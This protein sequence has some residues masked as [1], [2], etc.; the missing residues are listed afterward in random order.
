[1]Q[2]AAPQHEVERLANI[3]WQSIQEEPQEDPQSTGLRG[4][5]R[6]KVYYQLVRASRSRIREHK[7]P[8]PFLSARVALQTLSGTRISRAQARYEGVTGGNLTVREYEELL[9]GRFSLPIILVGGFPRSGTTSLQ[10][11]IRAGFPNHVCEVGDGTDRFS[12]WEQPKHD[13]AA[14]RDVASECTQAARIV[15]A[16]RDFREALASL[17]VGRGFWTIESNEAD[18]RSWLSWLPLASHPRTITVP[19]PDIASST[20]AQMLAVISG[21]IGI[22]TADDLGWAHSYRDVL[23]STGS[24]D[25]D[26][27]HKGNLPSKGRESRLNHALDVIDS[28]FGSRSSQIIAAYRAMIQ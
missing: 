26:H 17:I 24:G 5:W 1:M 25:P 9:C 2:A 22:A 4:L 7:N 23:A 15:L 6:R 14:L 21:R 18:L 10:A 16:V 27:I 28:Q 12:L 8:E 3:L 19:F 11:L 20:P 13:F